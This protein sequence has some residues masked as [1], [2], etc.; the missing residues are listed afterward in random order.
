MMPCAAMGKASFQ[1]ASLRGLADLTW[2]DA[3]KSDREWP[4]NRRGESHCRRC[5]RAGLFVNP[6]NSLLHGQP[7]NH[8]HRLRV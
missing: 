3:S 1:Q 5:V 2:R 7:T 8:R 6:E 4:R